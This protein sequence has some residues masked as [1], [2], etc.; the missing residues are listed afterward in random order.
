M[1]HSKANNQAGFSLIELMV[2]LGVMLVVVGA[3]FSLVKDS[4]KVSLAT[5]ELTDAQESVRIAHEFLT[6]DLTNVGDG[7]NSISNIRVTSSFVSNYLSTNS[8]I[9]LTHFGMITSD[10]D[11]PVGTSIPQPSP[12]P[13][14][15]IRSTPALTDRISILE[16]DANFTPITPVSIDP[17]GSAITVSLADANTVAAG[18]IYFL[19]SSLG[20]TFGTITSKAGSGATRQLNFASGDIYGLNVPG[21]GGQIYTVSA[22]GTVPTSLVRMQII[23]YYVNSSGLLMRRVFGV[24]G[25]GFKEAPIAE[26]IIGLRF[27]YILTDANGNVGQPVA[28]I[29]SSQQTATRQVEVTVTAETPHSIGIQQNNGQA[30]LSMTSSISIR[31]MQFKRA[32]QPS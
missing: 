9:D 6:R 32:L 17:S 28:Q 14:T 30:T 24:K 16:A 23:H 21:I 4:M 22:G 7:L 27:R 31:N 18:E 26:H 2:A 3:V 25:A 10:D 19:T 1:Q 8:S 5:H 12:S 11:V 15:T 13:A 29:D 20:A